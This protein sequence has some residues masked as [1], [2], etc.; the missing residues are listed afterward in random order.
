[1]L[2]LAGEPLTAI[3]KR[4]GHASI[5]TTSDTYGRMIEDASTGGLERVAAMLGAPGPAALPGVAGELEPRA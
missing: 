1:M 2:I 3:Q 5:K 4:L